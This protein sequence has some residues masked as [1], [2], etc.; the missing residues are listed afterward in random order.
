[1]TYKEFIEYN[2]TKDQGKYTENHHIIP[3]SEGGTDN[4]ENLIT[5]SWLAH[6][7]AHK[8]IVEVY[9]NNKQLHRLSTYSIERWLRRC[10]M[11]SQAHFNPHPQSEETKKKISSTLKGRPSPNKGNS[12]SMSEEAKEKI[13]KANRGRHFSEE[14]K[15]NLSI[16]HKGISRPSHAKGKKWKL[17]D[18]R[19][20]YYV[21]SFI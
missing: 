14:H 12:W 5:L 16:A 6:W 4:P 8:L 10:Y 2:R 21:E 7:Y 3:I 18:G 1:M 11:S 20:V 17:V 13:S 19:R 9:P 15:N